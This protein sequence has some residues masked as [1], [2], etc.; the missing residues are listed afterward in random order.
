ME[1]TKKSEEIKVSNINNESKISSRKGVV[2]FLIPTIIS[3]AAI[4][5]S[6]IDSE[7]MLSWLVKPNV[8][9]I[10]YEK[11][12][13]QELILSNFLIKNKGNKAAEDIDLAISIPISSTFGITDIRT[14]DTF[15]YNKDDIRTIYFTRKY[16]VPADSILITIESDTMTLNKYKRLYESQ[17]GQSGRRKIPNLLYFKSKE[18]YADSE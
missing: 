13:N 9:Y 4:F 3:L 10:S 18:G 16:L 11:E 5:I 8:Y 14:F 6:L 17:K 15:Q 12:R 2:S 1:E 7:L